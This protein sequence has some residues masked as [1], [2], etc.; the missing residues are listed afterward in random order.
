MICRTEKLD[1]DS[2]MFA[3]FG[4]SYKEGVLSVCGKKIQ[5]IMNTSIY[6]QISSMENPQAFIMTP[7]GR[8]KVILATTI[9]VAN[10][11]KFIALYNMVTYNCAPVNR[12][13]LKNVFLK[14]Y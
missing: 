6:T 1:V 12:G 5:L 14:I 2:Q 4:V 13:L 3:I 7:D 11:S 8:C 9:A 10:M